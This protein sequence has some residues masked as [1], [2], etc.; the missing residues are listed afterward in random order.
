[1]PALLRRDF[2]K[3]AALSAA[4]FPRVGSLGLSVSQSSA[5]KNADPVFQGS[6]KSATA[7]PNILFILADDIG[8]GDFGCYGAAKVVLPPFPDH[9]AKNASDRA[10]K[11]TRQQNL[12]VDYD[13]VIPQLAFA[14]R[15]IQQASPTNLPL[16]VVLEVTPA[17]TRRRN[18]SLSAKQRRESS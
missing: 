9:A 1:M 14:A 6:E 17:K 5:G 16:C 12:T 3:L 13:P 7:K 4:C 15:E 11:L 8:S 18:S 2:L 10:Q